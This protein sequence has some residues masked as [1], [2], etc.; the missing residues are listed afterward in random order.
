MGVFVAQKTVKLLLANRVNPAGARVNVLG[1]SFKEGVGDLRNS[2]TPDIVHEL[3]TYGVQVVVVD[4]RVDA[5]EANAQYGFDLVPFETLTA[6]DATVLAVAHSEFI[7]V[8]ALRRVV[9]QGSVLV[10]VKAAL[11]PGDWTGVR[12]WAL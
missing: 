10:D 4:P 1:L 5:A 2:R 6:A 7:D 12:Y 9:P 11:A 3:E 8:A